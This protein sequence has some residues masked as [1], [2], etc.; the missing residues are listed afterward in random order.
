VL[1]FGLLAFNLELGEAIFTAVLCERARVTD[2]KN[3]SILA[4]SMTA[5]DASSLEEAFQ[6]FPLFT[7]KDTDNTAVRSSSIVG[8]MC[9]RCRVLLSTNL[10]LFLVDSFYFE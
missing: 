8:L 9:G 7:L 2:F 4:M 10:L 5:F 1:F 6:H 3:E